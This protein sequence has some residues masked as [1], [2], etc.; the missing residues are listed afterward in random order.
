MQRYVNR[1]VHIPHL[2][3]AIILTEAV[4]ALGAFHCLQSLHTWY[5]TLAKSFILPD[6]VFTSL[7]IIVYALAGA[8]A[9]RIWSYGDRWHPSLTIFTVM[10]GLN[11]LWMPLFWQWHTP[12]PALIVLILV[13]VLAVIT[14]LLFYRRSR[15]AAALF[16]PYLLWITCGIALNYMIW[17]L[18]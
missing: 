13:E 15:I 10:M 14:V 8:A 9:Y 11:A 3:A 17:K 16:L 18:N 12:L 4:G 5:P 1:Y 2:A 7:W 6:W